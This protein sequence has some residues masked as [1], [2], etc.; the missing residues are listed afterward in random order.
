M[1][2]GLEGGTDTSAALKPPATGSGGASAPSVISV[3][4]RV[5]RG[6]GWSWGGA[7][8]G[9]SGGYGTVID[10]RGGG[11]FFVACVGFAIGTGTAVWLGPVSS[12]KRP[13]GG[14]RLGGRCHTYADS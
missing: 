13:T 14:K 11:Y 4:D 3:G 9:G 12:R 1:L 2:L 5:V 6:P 8:D 10:V 7:P